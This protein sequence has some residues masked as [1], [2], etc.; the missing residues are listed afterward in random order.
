M[1]NPEINL[2]DYELIEIV[3]I[4]PGTKELVYDIEVDSPE[5]A[6]IAISPDGAIGI[7][8]NSACISL[9]NLSDER[10]RKAKSGQWWIEHPEYA[11]ANN[12]A[13]YTD[14]PEIELFLGEWL[15]LIESKSGERGIFN[16]YATK[17]H[18]EK[19]GKRD[20]NIEYLCNPCSE[21]NLRSMQ[22]CNLTE[23]IV[24]HD[25]TFETLK[26]KAI[27]ASI[28]GTFQAS[29]TAYRYVRKKWQTNNEEE[30]LL[31]VSLTGIMD[32]PIL[33]G[34]M[35]PS[36]VPGFEQFNTLPEVLEAL[37]DVCITTNEEYAKIIGI[38]KATATTCV[39]PSGTVSQ[40]VNSASGIHA[41]YSPYYIRTVRN[42]K[43]DPLSRFL[44]DNG[45]PYEDDVMKPESTY[46]FSFPIKS[47]DNS[48]Y[49]NDMS[50]IEQLEHWL[51]YQK[52]WCE[53]KPSVTIYVKDHEWL[54]VGAWVYKHFDEVSGV[55]FLP[56][57]NHTYKQAPYQEITEEEYISLLAKMPKIDMDSF[58]EKEDDTTGMKEYACVGGA[59]EI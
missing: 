57:S 53:H 39:K 49:R 37:R 55:S 32:H 36:E 12:S 30:A 43:K 26:Q 3:S 5:H 18:I 51:I 9:S 40:L 4:T 52:H 56:H 42:D 44:V 8:H 17:K 31:G 7:S 58:I 21:I 47:P 24:R 16:R 25:D 29:L 50:A 34:K 41:R 46:V 15:S 23:I 13:V 33:N 45:F 27:K 59:C 6:F 20:P 54:D 19:L 22:S 10:M 2:D 48:I 11:L 38:N 1:K 35:S 28:L 14:K